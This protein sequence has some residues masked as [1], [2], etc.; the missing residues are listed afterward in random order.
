[1]FLLAG[2]LAFGQAQSGAQSQEQGKGERKGGA[3][4]TGC[5][6]KGDTAGSYTLTTRNGRKMTVT[7]TADF[8][9]HV[10][11]TVRLEGK[12]G[13]QQDSYEATGLTHIAANCDAGSE[14]TKSKGGKK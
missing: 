14:D 12:R 5:L 7:G 13:S 4:M 10:G 3:G 2:A 9:K 11:H 1:M 8:E 6:S